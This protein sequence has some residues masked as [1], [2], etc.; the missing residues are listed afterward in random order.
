MTSM[1]QPLLLM[2]YVDSLRYSVRWIDLMGVCQVYEV[3]YE[4]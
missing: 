3:L 4:G 1:S 2:R